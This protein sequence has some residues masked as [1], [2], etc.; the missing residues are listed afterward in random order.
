MKYM[1]SII[2]ALVILFSGCA[3]RPEPLLLIEIPLTMV[4]TMDPY[5][6][7]K[8]PATWTPGPTASNTPCPSPKATNSQT[9]LSTPLPMDPPGIVIGEGIV[10]GEYPEIITSLVFIREDNGKLAL[11]NIA[12]DDPEPTRLLLTEEDIFSPVWS[13]D[14]TQL[15]FL[16][17]EDYQEY[18]DR[19]TPSDLYLYIAGIQ[20]LL[21]RSGGM[22]ITDLAWSRDSRLIA[23]SGQKNDSSG[24]A[25]T[26]QN[27]Y[28]VSIYSQK[29]TL[30]LESALGNVG[31]SSPSWDPDSAELVARCR[32]GMVTG[33]GIAEADGSNPWFLELWSFD[34]VE[35]LPNGG[36]LA[37]IGDG[38]R[39]NVI[40]APLLYQR[41]PDGDLNI[42]NLY[43]YVGNLDVQK[44]ATTGFSWAT[45][46]DSRFII[47]SND[48][49]QIV[50]YGED[51]VVSVQ[52]D[53]KGLDG[54]FSWGPLGNQIAFA[55]YDGHDIEIGV[56][57]FPRSSFYQLTNNQVDDIM[58]AWQP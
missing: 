6:P 54:Q 45:A 4:N 19:E 23:F 13:P 18:L 34:E 32:G 51:K 41:D 2:F 9:P 44:N 55:Y 7:V 20:A 26:G 30:V 25:Q 35:W 48:L 58:P 47:Q 40:D 38:N 5:T 37:I 10:V 22:Y 12:A 50:D 17:T 43:E 21:N 46:R 28:Q 16:R 39:L 27:I 14:G 15:A 56:V 42:L 31:C 57:N 53:F 36:T 52:G 3:P 33:L 11:F 8:L 24:F 49:I 1:I 29:I